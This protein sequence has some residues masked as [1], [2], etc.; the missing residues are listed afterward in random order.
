MALANWLS[1]KVSKT[2]PGP[3]A[4][5]KPAAK[6]PRTLETMSSSKVAASEP[7][8][9]NAKKKTREIRIVYLLPMRDVAGRARTF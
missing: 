6:P 5:I 8:R 2:M 7:Q 3:R 1:G 9:L 4:S